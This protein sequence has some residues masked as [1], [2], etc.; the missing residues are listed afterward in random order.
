MKKGFSFIELM[1]AIAIVA[2]L[3]AIGMTAF[4]SA[5]KR[6]RDT[7]RKSDLETVRSALEM[8]RADNDE[9]P[10]CG[11]SWVRV[12]GDPECLTTTLVDTGYLD[13]LPRD[14]KSSGTN[15]GPCYKVNPRAYRYT[16][17]GNGGSSYFV[18][19]L[20]ELSGS[21]DDSPCDDIADFWPTCSGTG[22]DSE[23]YCYAK[24]DP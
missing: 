7:R 22:Y 23:D 10:D 11:A 18:A 1:I 21:K 6:A 15:N 13:S 17:F 9:Y 3:T 24:T 12:D 2:L 5:K 4:N 14:P 8:Y 16:Y 20:M 19:T